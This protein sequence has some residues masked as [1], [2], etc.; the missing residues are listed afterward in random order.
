M[1]IGYIA[2]LYTRAEENKKTY[3]SLN[4]ILTVG[5]SSGHK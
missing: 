5:G 1:S 3:T 4:I 2:G